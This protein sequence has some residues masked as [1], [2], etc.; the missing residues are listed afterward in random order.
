[1]SKTAEDRRDRTITRYIHRLFWRA[2]WQDKW[3]LIICYAMRLPALIM[4]NV[5][6]PLAAAYGIQAIVTKNFDAVSHYAWI[7]LAM[8]LGY[9]VFWTISG[10]YIDRNG[11]IGSKYLQRT[12]FRNYLQK[13]YEFYGN[14]FFGALGS[15]ATQLRSVYSEYCQIMTLVLPKQILII[16]V[17]IIIIAL[18]SLLLA[19]VTLL[20]ML[21]VLSFTIL[22]GRYRLRLRRRL[23]EA[24]SQ[25]AGVI[26]DAISHAPTVK[27]FASEKQEDEYLTKS[28]DEWGTIQRRTWD[29][30]I[31][32][33]AGLWTLSALA[34]VSLLLLTSHMYQAGTISIAIVTLVQLYVLRMVIATQVIADVVKQYE[35]VMGAAYQAVRTMLVEPTVLDSVTPK[36]VPSD[37]R[38]EVTFKGVGYRYADAK[39]GAQAVSEFDLTIKKGEKIGLVGYSGSGKTTL[40]KLLMRFIDVT[41][42][43]ITLGGI[44]IR[45]VTQSDLRSKI[46]YVPQ[47]PLLFHRTIRE[48][49]A[50]GR[51][52]ASMKEIE[53]AAHLAYVDEFVEELPKGYDTMVGERGVKL[54]GGQRQR[55]AIARALLKNAPILVLDEATSA[56][57]SRSEKLIQEA[58]WHLMKDRTALVVAHRL[59]T[60]QRMDRIVVMDK[61]RIVQIGTHDELLKDKKGQYAVLWEHQSGGYVGVKPE[62][63]TEA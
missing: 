37:D 41:E 50:Y 1:M 35:T 10:Y 30:A 13:D 61:G 11:M 36:K 6:I 29:S 33:D 12:I 38:L 31:P 53:H 56:L 15:Q 32:A 46:A 17:G 24:S 28:L 59:S 4:V 23:S 57:D 5:F 43:A 14:S 40:T 42:G 22:F 18:H 8:S 7:I 34:T 44:D 63:V 62:T 16:G 39:A 2:N 49:I 25:L 3:S 27:S 26:G 45:D 20:L 47:E 48:N 55:V 51:P 52:G 54:S 19:G 58:L 21:G 9:T 60:I